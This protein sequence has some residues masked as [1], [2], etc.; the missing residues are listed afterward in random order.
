MKRTLRMTNDQ[1]RI[2]FF[3]GPRYL[4]HPLICWARARRQADVPQDTAWVEF[5]TTSRDPRGNNVWDILPSGNIEGNQQAL[6]YDL[7]DWLRVSHK[8]GCKYLT[9]YY[10]ARKVTIS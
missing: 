4:K 8:R 10:S 1:S 3:C 9:V 7:Q 2:T 6:D 5:V